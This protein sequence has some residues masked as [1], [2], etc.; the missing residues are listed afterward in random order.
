M[1]RERRTHEWT[2]GAA[3]RR[4]RRCEAW[5]SPIPTCSEC[6]LCWTCAPETCRRTPRNRVRTHAKPLSPLDGGDGH[7]TAVISGA[8]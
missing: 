5:H 2:D 6:G 4:G 7:D 3:C 1:A 8:A